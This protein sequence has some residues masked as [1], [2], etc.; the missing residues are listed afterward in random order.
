MF[1]RYYLVFAVM[2]A[3][4]AFTAIMA[5]RWLAAPVL[6]VVAAGFVYARFRLM[7]R[8]NDLRDRALAGDAQAEAGFDRA[9][10]LSVRL[11]MGQLAA[12]LATFVLVVWR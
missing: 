12:L 7:P 11:N 3:L 2:S 10:R 5:E 9:H 6:V 4:A 8:I 1:P